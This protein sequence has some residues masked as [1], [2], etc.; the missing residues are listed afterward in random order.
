LL[1]FTIFSS[2]LLISSI[3]ARQL[4]QDAYTSWEGQDP[5]GSTD[6]F[7]HAAEASTASQIKGV[8]YTT[9]EQV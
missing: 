8:Y 1:H 7:A 9:G 5:G 3:D 4:Q 2:L 6:S